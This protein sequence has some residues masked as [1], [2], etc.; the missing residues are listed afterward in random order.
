MGC[1]ATSCCYGVTTSYIGADMVIGEAGGTVT[2]AGGGTVMVKT[3]HFVED[4]IIIMV[5]GIVM[6]NM[7]TTRVRLRIFWDV[8]LIP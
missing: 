2:L 4:G 3:L 8:P 7:Q 1:N 5:L 6:M